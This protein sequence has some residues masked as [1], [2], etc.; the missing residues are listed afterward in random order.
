MHTSTGL[1]NESNDLTSAYL[2]RIEWLRSEGSCERITLNEA[3]VREFLAF[4]DTES[5]SLRA[6][7]V[8]LDNGN[9][10]AVWKL[11]GEN[12]IGIQFRGDGNA[13]F[14]IFNRLASGGATSRTYG[15]DTLDG[16]RAR[17]R[18][19]GFEEKLSGRSTDA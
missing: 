9:I 10:Q 16:V 19:C 7:L 5:Y 17:I 13:S 3:S 15:V 1:S 8:L 6:S 18:A 11:G 12:R 4:V 14:V 2:Q